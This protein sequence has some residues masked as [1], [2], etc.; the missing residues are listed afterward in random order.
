L[1]AGA[2]WIRHRNIRMEVWNIEGGGHI[3][4]EVTKKDPY[5]EWGV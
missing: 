5:V 2:V 4:L 3:I 1:T